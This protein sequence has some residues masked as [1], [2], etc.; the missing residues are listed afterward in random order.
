M[1][2]RPHLA[3]QCPFTSCPFSPNLTLHSMV[4][5]FAFSAGLSRTAFGGRKAVPSLTN[6]L[7]MPVSHHGMEGLV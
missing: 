1:T 7:K 3:N 6:Q 5:V 4:S 2:A